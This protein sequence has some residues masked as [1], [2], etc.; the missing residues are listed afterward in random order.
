MFRVG[1]IGV[2]RF[3]VLKFGVEDD[4]TGIVDAAA[5]QPD[6]EFGQ[7]PE[8]DRSVPQSGS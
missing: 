1:C 7:P 6:F 4:I 2:E 3:L 5:V 8:C